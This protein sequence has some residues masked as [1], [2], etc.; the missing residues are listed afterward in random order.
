MIYLKIILTIIAF[1]LA[2]QIVARIIPGVTA[3][4]WQNVNISAIGGKELFIVGPSRDSIPVYVTN[5]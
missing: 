4:S 1:L 5:K 2:V 3:S